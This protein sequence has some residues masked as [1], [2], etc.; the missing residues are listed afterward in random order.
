MSTEL[1][2]LLGFAALVVLLAL[3]VPVGIA[4]IVVS[5][6]GYSTVVNPDAALARLGSDAFSGTASYSLSVIPLFVLMGLVLAQSALG[7]DLYR[8]LNSLLWRLRGGLALAT[9]GAS[10]LFGS[11]SGSA[12]ASASTMSLVA[13][14]EMRRYRYDEGLGAACVAVGGTLGSLIPPSA[15]LVLYGILTEESIGAL[16]IGGILPGLLTT[17]VLILTAY[18]VVRMYPNLAPRM[19]EHGSPH[20]RIRLLLRTW[21]VPTIFGISM[22]GIYVGVFTPTE[23]GGAGAFLAL[24]YGVLARRLSWAGFVEAVS[25]TVRLS[26]MI[27]LIVI[28]GQMF[29][30][31]LSATGIPSTLGNYVA[32]LEIAP[33]MVAAL[34][35]LIYMA[36]GTL[37]DE[38]AILVIMTPI[39]YPIMLTLGYDGVWFGVLSIMM[40]LSGLLTPPVG[41]IAFIV[42]RVAE[43][44][45]GRVFRAVA[46]F[47]AAL[48]VASLLVIIFPQIVLFLP[49]LMG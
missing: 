40:L 34:I 35:L 4:M 6:V 46:P 25:Q 30:F 38:I 41:I 16:L 31:F 20:S 1:V 17:A 9:V 15:V 37:M 23:A 11:V 10:A 28:A 3:R 33:W 44:P 22:G 45:L 29:G 19:T 13:M 42:S 32:G 7:T 36:L 48:V 49:E 39:M 18:V 8:F 12:T 2:G 27:F 14:P 21:A 26:A 5:I 24:V 47:W 43:V